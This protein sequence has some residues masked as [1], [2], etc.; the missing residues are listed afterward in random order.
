LIRERP[1]GFTFIEIMAVVMLIA[2]ISAAMV[3]QIGSRSSVPLRYSGR[4]L[5]AELEYVGQRA[6]ATGRPQRWLIDLDAQLFRVEQLP[7]PA[8]LDTTE[9]V[10]LAA[11]LPPENWEPIPEPPGE[12]RELVE[13]SIGIYAL[14]VAGEEW[15]AGQV[16]IHF[17][18]DG[19]ADP[20]DIWLLDEE[21]R[22]LRVGVIGFTG[23]IAVS[24]P[25]AGGA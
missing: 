25:E 18:P 13:D 9:V 20:A 3:T 19:G 6:I 8:A 17:A 7:E 24:E 16:A 12:W 23:E 22:H 15:R 4:F 14:V 10:D 2:L 21:N 1:P 11:P 5:S